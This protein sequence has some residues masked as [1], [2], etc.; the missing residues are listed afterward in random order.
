MKSWGYLGNV[1][2]GE[3]PPGAKIDS[4][5]YKINFQE[6]PRQGRRA[7]KKFL[8]GQEILFGPD[9][10]FLRQENVSKIML[11]GEVEKNIKR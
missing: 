4:W 7:N 3:N 2:A 5:V 8:D 1:R 9:G 10:G 11:Y 6:A